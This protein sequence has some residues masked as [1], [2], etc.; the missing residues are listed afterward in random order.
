MRKMVKYQ[1]AA[2]RKNAEACKVNVRLMIR[3]QVEKGFQVEKDAHDAGKTRSLRS[4]PLDKGNGA[5][6]DPAGRVD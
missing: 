1:Q 4:D 5:L 6:D 2:G 3:R